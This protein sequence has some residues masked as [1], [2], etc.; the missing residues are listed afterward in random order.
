MLVIIAHHYVVNSELFPLACESPS[1]K[2]ADIFLLI[3]GWGGK[4]GINCF[5]L[6]TG[7]F[8]CKSK[9]TALKYGK[10]LGEVYFYKIL[11][12]L[13]FWLSGYSEFSVKEL[14]KALFPFYTVQDNFTGCFF[15]FYLFI[16]FLNELIHTLT[17]KE[18]VLLTALCLFIYTVLPSFINAKVGYSYATWFMVLCLIASYIRLYPKDIF[19]NACRWGF[20]TVGTVLCSWMSV[21]ALAWIGHKIG[22]PYIAYFLVSDSNKMLALV[23]A[24]CAFLFFRNLK[25]RQSR[26]INTV[27]ASTFGVFMIHANSDTMRQWLWKDILTNGR[28]YDSHW[29]YLHAVASVLVIYIIC[30]GIDLLRRLLLEKS[31]LKWLERKIT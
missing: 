4:T 6:I 3:F 31:S 1:L 24:L 21:V 9:I 8:M 17:E 12:S 10:L 2:A 19:E 13:I 5:V 25:I 16:P 27:A 11:F 7:Y 15:L 23:T 14:I 30:T 29:L 18:H 26:L 20:L 22:K 28:W